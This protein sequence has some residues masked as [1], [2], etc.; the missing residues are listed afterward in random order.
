MELK[1]T[2]TY[3]IDFGEAGEVDCEVMGY[4]TRGVRASGEYGP[5]ENYDPGSA[6]ELRVV[7]VMIGR[8]DVIKSIAKAD[9]DL[10]EENLLY[11]F[12]CEEENT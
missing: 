4:Y 12:D 6:S 9:M 8:D 3:T 10:I 11:E 5:P 7:K 1:F 2:E